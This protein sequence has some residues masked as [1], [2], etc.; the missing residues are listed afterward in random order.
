MPN[1]LLRAR[2]NQSGVATNRPV[3][4]EPVPE[5]VDGD[6]WPYRGIVDHG[7]DATNKPQLDPI[8]NEVDT[9]GKAKPYTYEV[10]HAEPDP[11][12]V[13][14]VRTDFGR[15]FREFWTDRITVTTDRP[16]S[17]LGRDENRVTV[18]LMN[19]DTTN[20][21]YIASSAGDLALRGYPLMPG[22]DLTVTGE[23]AVYAIANGASCV[24]AMYAETVVPER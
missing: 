8:T 19:T 17:L 16:V 20:T 2:M 4:V 6:N 11:I 15:E 3:P 24:L 9:T 21:V 1:P 14:I 10:Q 7:V 12:P 18:R 22:K 13:R 5:T 23:M